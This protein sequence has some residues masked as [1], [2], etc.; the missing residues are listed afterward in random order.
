[1][2][3]PRASHVPL[4]SSQAWGWEPRGGAAKQLT[5]GQDIVALLALLDNEPTGQMHSD[6]GPV[7]G[8]K[9]CALHLDCTSHHLSG[10]IEA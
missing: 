7:W 9:Y 3:T 5:V 1:M 10:Q 6:H 2:P 4:L 8:D